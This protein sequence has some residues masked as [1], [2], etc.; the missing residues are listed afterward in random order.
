MQHE[1]K[2]AQT[3]TSGSRI[4]R[5]PVL[6]RCYRIHDLPEKVLIKSCLIYNDLE[7]WKCD[8]TCVRQI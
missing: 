3:E 7:I 6:L 5:P 4:K 8:N 2:E 1:R